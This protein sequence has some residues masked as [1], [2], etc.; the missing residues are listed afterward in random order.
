MSRKS[1]Q[2]V[3][4]QAKR[5]N[6]VKVGPT[7]VRWCRVELDVEQASESTFDIMVGIKEGKRSIK[8]PSTDKTFIQM[9][10]ASF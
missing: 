5:S 9:L 8:V 2:A 1:E 10:K 7:I 6:F 4:H 3:A